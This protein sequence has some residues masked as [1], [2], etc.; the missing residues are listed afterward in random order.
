[1][2]SDLEAGG[3]HPQVGPLPGRPPLRP[4]NPPHL[5]AGGKHPISSVL[6]PL[7]LHEGVGEGAVG[8]ELTEARGEEMVPLNL[9]GEREG[10]ARGQGYGLSLI[11]MCHVRGMA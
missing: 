4:P 7:E 6:V 2:S 3:K 10:I 11:V 5:E 9:R 8:L 1:M